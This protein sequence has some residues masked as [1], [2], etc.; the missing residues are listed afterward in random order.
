[1][2]SSIGR[3]L[4]RVRATPALVVVLVVSLVA[5]IVVLGEPSRPATATVVRPV[6]TVPA[7]CSAPTVI[8]V[9]ARD[10]TRGLTAVGQLLG[11][12]DELVGEA[13]RD[14]RIV[15]TDA[16]AFFVLV[17][18]DE[19]RVAAL[20]PAGLPIVN[21]EVTPPQ[22]FRAFALGDLEGRPS[23]VVGGPEGVFVVFGGEGTPAE[24]FALT[25]AT[26]ASSFE[27]S[28]A[29]D[30]DGPELA[31]PL[32]QAGS[33]VVH[34]GVL[35]L[36]GDD[37]RV[38]TFDPLAEA[39]ERWEE[40]AEGLVVPLLAQGE[41]RVHGVFASSADEATVEVRSFRSEG[42]PA[43]TPI[44]T[45]VRAVTG[46]SYPEST[47]PA[48]AVT[49]DGG[50]GLL[51]PDDERTSVVD[52]PA[53]EGRLLGLVA[54]DEAA[55]LVT[56][57]GGN[58][59]YEVFDAVGTPVGTFASEGEGRCVVGPWRD[60]A[61]VIEPGSAGSLLHLHDPSSAWDCV[62]DTREPSA[63]AELTE[64]CAPDGAWSVDK[65][66][67]PA[68][69][70][71]VEI[72]RALDEL[73]AD[74]L[75]RDTESDDTLANF[76]AEAIQ[77]ELSEA[78]IGVIE[79]EVDPEAA[80]ECAAEQVTSVAPPVLDLAEPIG[81]RA[82][83]I[84]WS[85]SGGACLPGRY[86]VTM[87]RLT[88]Q[89]SECVDAEE[90][91]VVANPTSARSSLELAARPD[92]TYRVTVR[93][94]KG[95]ILSAPSGA[96]LVTTPAVTPD[97]PVDVSGSLEAGTW[98]LAWSSCLAGGDCDQRPDGF[99]VTVEG[100]D[101]DGLG[102]VRRRFDVAQRGTS[103]GAD[104]AGFG[105][106]DLLGRRVQFRVA[107]TFQER[108]SEPVAAGGCTRSVR[109]GRDTD[110][111]NLGISLTGRS[112]QI[113]LA[114]I[115]G[116]RQ[117]SELFGTT[118]YDSVRA[119]LLRGGSTFSADG[120]VLTGPVTFTVDRCATSGWT[121]EL[122]PRSNGNDLTVHRSRLTDAV[123]TC[124]P[125]VDSNTT[126][127]TSY[128]DADKQDG[129]VLLVT[130]PGLGQD[131]LNGLVAGVTGTATC[132]R[133]FSASETYALSGGSLSG[134]DVRFRIPTV[135]AVLDLQ[136]ACVISPVVSF[137][138]G[139]SAAPAG[140]SLDLRQA[141]PLIAEEVLPI[142]V[143][144]LASARTGRYQQRLETVVEVRHGGSGVPCSLTPTSYNGSLWRFEVS[145]GTTP[146]PDRC[147]GGAHN[148]DYY[149][150][151]LDGGVGRLRVEVAVGAASAVAR[152]D[153]GVC[154]L[155]EG[156]RRWP[157]GEPCPY[158]DAI[159]VNDPAC[160]EPCPYD[161]LI[162]ADH[163]QC[164]EPCPHDPSIS[165]DDPACRPGP[166]PDGGG[167]GGE[168]PGQRSAT[169]SSTALAAISS[170]WS[171]SLRRT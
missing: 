45:P 140:R 62:V 156:D 158:N 79:T 40:R 98:Q 78:G 55:A 101:G 165:A 90:R 87:C 117:L 103:F 23:L 106:V 121:V 34:E 84:E 26:L 59:G 9:A 149:R 135:P 123:V 51:R 109:P 44:T 171:R 136:A 168:P 13:G 114:A 48:F 97:P 12:G 120:N 1:M 85:W 111:A 128:V 57:R 66:S 4:R 146:H 10:A 118:A 100:C 28:V 164:P 139:G 36:A 6:V 154:R 70:F 80:D 27:V 133:A 11:L 64:R 163:P 38:V 145:G 18:G 33:A 151:D 54:T 160:P 115:S 30:P 143:R 8:D 52:I 112:Q 19:L 147:G 159:G 60:A 15:D 99:L 130:I 93:A 81:A 17:Q 132:A 105:D 124:N 32:A 166:P 157:C 89:G 152:L 137:R 31:D 141:G 108:V 22:T 5:A 58:L 71:T 155:P 43:V 122:T 162:P 42:A 153:L 134:D 50:A 131:D 3:L 119:R 138:G 167:P 169:P 127:S 67:A 96:L 25:P 83:R 150:R 148:L 41:L 53:V 116:S 91:E 82:V 20:G 107:T 37:G 65:G 61:A 2:A 16:G 125:S 102:Q 73:A 126:I 110:A 46:V 69:D 86:V 21:A 47:R 113:T 39:G 76:A 63:L 29:R 77:E 7:L 88:G 129:V 49:T 170:L 95:E 24:V 161:P 92:R 68:R 75:E 142:V 94:G 72:G 14:V 74:D 56:S 104:G 144:R 35:W